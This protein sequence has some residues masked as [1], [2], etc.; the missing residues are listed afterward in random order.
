[1]GG[2]GRGAANWRNGAAAREDA[3]FAS[4]SRVPV[5]GSDVGVRVFVSGFEKRHL[6]S[7]KCTTMDLNL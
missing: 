4:G 1:V 7:R 5:G 3:A 6:C 2:C